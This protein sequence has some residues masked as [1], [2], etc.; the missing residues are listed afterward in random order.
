[1]CCPWKKLWINEEI[2][3]IIEGFNIPIVD[4][5]KI[6][7][8]S[9]KDRIQKVKIKNLKDNSVSE[10]ECDALLL[11]VNFE[12]DDALAKKAKILMPDENLITISKDYS[13]SQNGVFA[14]GNVV[15]GEKAFALKDNNGIECGE[16]AANYIKSNYTN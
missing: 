5:S 4:S 14:C 9:G 2:K 15:Y 10:I 3:D 16:Q 8:V 11:T 1:M 6:I 7:E 12:P 13:T